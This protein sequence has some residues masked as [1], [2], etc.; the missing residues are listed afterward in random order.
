MNNSNKKKLWIGVL[1]GAIISM[2]TLAALVVVFFL[3]FLFGKQPVEITTGIEE[4]EKAMTKYD[5]EMMDTAF[6]V[7]PEKIPDSA[8]DTDFY[9]SY[10]EGWE[11]SVE[12]FLQCTYNEEDY[13]AE[14][15]RLENTKKQYGGTVRK[16]IQLEESFSN[17]A[18]I[19]V[20]G[21]DQSFEYALLTGENQITYIYTRFHDSESLKKIKPEY[22]PK[23]YDKKLEA[24]QLEEGYT[25]YLKSV[26]V[27][28]G[29]VI[30]WELDYTR[31]EVVEVLNYHP[32]SIK[33]N[34]FGVC[35]YLDE[36]NN[37]IIKNCYYSY[38]ENM[39]DALYGL[40]EE[41][42]YTELQGYRFKSVKL[43]KDKTQALVTY[44]DGEEEKSLEYEL[45]ET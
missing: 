44:Y 14:V 4:Y 18:Y 35:T 20:D 32:V 23:D 12:V 8:K 21:H 26:D 1:V 9:Y 25:I 17:P 22:L 31:D 43:N 41:I 15:Q 40:P 19:A 10:Q 36:E 34:N 24:F 38:Y 11:A 29:E 6:I 3:F 16:L 37:E 7:F 33:F 13:Q 27:E 45:P 28:D 42:V 39:H 5:C 30:A 2:L